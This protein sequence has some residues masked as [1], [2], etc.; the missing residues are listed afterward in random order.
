MKVEQKGLF[1]PRTRD[2]VIRQ[3]KVGTKKLYGRSM[4]S[5]RVVYQIFKNAFWYIK[6]TYKLSN[7]H[8]H[9]YCTK[10]L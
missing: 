1:L 5:Q 2:L 6:S 4:Y 9:T 10:S 8:D 3:A 7:P